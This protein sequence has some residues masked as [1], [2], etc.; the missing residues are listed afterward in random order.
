[1]YKIILKNKTLHIEIVFKIHLK[2]FQVS[3]KLLFYKIL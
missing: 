3:N 1:M 2:I